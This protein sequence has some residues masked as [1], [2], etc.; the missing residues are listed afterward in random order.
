MMSL[1]EHCGNCIVSRCTYSYDCPVVLCEFGC[2]VK[3]HGCK[4]SDHGN[5]CQSQRISCINSYYGCPVNVVRSRLSSHL[6]HCPA[7]VIFCTMEWGRYPVY[8]GERLRWVPFIQ[9]NPALVKGYLDVEL[10]VSDQKVI[11]KTRQERNK[12][13]LLKTPCERHDPS[14]KPSYKT[15]RCIRNE[16]QK[17]ATPMN[18]LKTT[19]TCHL[20]QSQSKSKMVEMGSQE[21][22]IE[23][24]DVVSSKDIETIPE[25]PPMLETYSGLGLNL[26]LETIPK[27]FKHNIFM[28]R[29]Q[30]SQILHRR[31]FP[32]H[33]K[34]VHSD[35]HGGLG[36]IEQR[37][38]FAQYGCSYVHHRLHPSSQEA[39]VVFSQDLGT[40]G[41]KPVKSID[42]CPKDCYLMCLP[43][44]VLEV[45]CEWLDGF[46]L[47]NLSVTCKGLH[48]F[49][50]HLLLKK[51]VVVVQ[52]KKRIYEDGSAS[53]MIHQKVGPVYCFRI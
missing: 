42:H 51:G 44:E 9:R 52:W 13:G 12:R 11:R 30:C 8:S 49:M 10:A 7:N 48:H 27:Y 37:C 39:S 43:Y 4:M 34:N 53:W 41:I 38:P 40:F 6:L 29:V 15:A 17:M 45:I 32:A 31:E 35:I 1:H 3:L 46:S 25:C 20:V 33:F 36:W 26:N 24:I 22:A 19:L 16:I 2:G 18:E 23:E 47:C 21:E 28:Y 5:L 50:F 14:M